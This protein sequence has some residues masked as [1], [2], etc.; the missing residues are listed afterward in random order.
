MLIR[1]IARTILGI[2]KAGVQVFIAT[3]SLF[4]LREFEILL[5][6]DFETVKRRYFALSRGDDGVEVS[7]GDQIEDINPLV[8]LDEDFAQ[9]ERFIEY[10]K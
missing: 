10:C 2:C 3:H 6:K 1:D 8:L 7:Q 4:L 9:S 5:E